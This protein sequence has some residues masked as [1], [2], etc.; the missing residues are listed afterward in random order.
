MLHTILSALV[1]LVVGGLAGMSVYLILKDIFKIPTGNTIKSVVG[2]ER[3]MDDSES[4]INTSLEQVAIWLSKIIKMDEYKKASMEA[5]LQTARIMMT[6]EMFVANAIVKAGVFGI[7]AIPL[8]FFKGAFWKIMASLILFIAFVMYLNETR[9]L[10]GRIRAKRQTIEYELPRLVSTIEKTLRHS[11]DVITMLE[12]YVLVA[13]PDMKYELEI[14]LADMRSGNY[15]TA[16]TR[17]ESRIGSPMMSDVCRGLISVMRGDD[18]VVYWQSLEIK[19]EDYQ[20]E[21]LKAEA[22]K[23]PNK[24]RR[25]SLIMLLCFLLVWIVVI[26]VQVVE[27]LTV[28]FSA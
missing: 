6:P 10:A 23:I 28:I 20:R 17:L 2:L 26:G 4:R 11:R 12:S 24:T 3:Q 22:N 13:G 18:T 21:M 15:E 7:V 14:T 25:L 16:I 27:S 5:D 8:F 9:S 19:F 1:Q